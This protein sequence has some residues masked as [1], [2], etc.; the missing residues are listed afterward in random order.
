MGQWSVLKRLTGLLLASLVALA[1]LPAA[2]QTPDRSM[3][4]YHFS[5]GEQ[6][7]LTGDSDTAISEMRKALKFDPRA[8]EIRAELARQL[9]DLGKIEE[10]FAEAKEAVAADRSS[11]AAHLVLAQLHQSQVGTL[12]EEGFRRAAAEYEEVVRLEPGDG[13]S[14]LVLGA[15]YGQLQQH[16]EA[17]SAWERYIDLDPGNFEAHVRLGTHYLGL[18]QPDKAAAALKKALELQPSSSRAY[19]KLGDV[20]AQAQQS[21][22]AVLHYRKALELDPGD[23]RVRLQLGEVLFSARRYREAL[24]EADAVLAADQKNRYGLELKG[25]VLRELKDFDAA[26]KAADQALALDPKDLRA[27]FLKV[28][29]AEAR[30]EYQTAAEGLEAILSRNRT[31]EEPGESINNDRIFL[32]RLGIAYQQLG[33]PAEAA[34]AFRKAGTVAGEPDAELIEYRVEA[35]VQAKD[36]DKAQAEVRAARLRFPKNNDLAFLE[37]SVLREKG[38]AKGAFEIVDKLKSSSPQ[39]AKVLVQTARFYQRA[40]RYKDAAQALRQAKAI[41]PKSLAVLFQLGAV[42][43]RQRLH[44]EA[45]ATFR[46]ALVLQPDSA[47]VLNYLGYMNADRGVHVEEALQFIQKAVEVDPENGAYL[48]SLGWALHRLGRDPAAEE[49]LKKA[50]AKQSNNAVILDH[51][52]DVL[53]KRGAAKEALEFWR[54]ALKG[55]DD[56]GELD[57]AKLERKIKEA[58]RP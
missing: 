13:N 26:K 31:G 17:A 24:S 34:E 40:K 58:E 22:Q 1:T 55:E 9:R 2:A 19:Q 56:D 11:V 46:E 33:R 30:Q 35:L 8:A 21:E 5:L 41:E 42:L 16:K 51:L 14:L 15:L 43:E 49:A 44:D 3:A 20:Y 32:A 10:A 4:Y 39:D 29:I 48:D 18:G 38:D 7:R 27:A 50:V 37:A 6:A 53:S 23:L 36:L 28:T 52:G 45:E 57:R 12:G 47:P 54:R 25:R